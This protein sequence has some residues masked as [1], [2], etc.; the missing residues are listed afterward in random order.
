MEIRGRVL[1]NIGIRIVI[2]I[3][4]IAFHLQLLGFYL[5]AKETHL[6]SDTSSIVIDIGVVRSGR[7]AVK[8]LYWHI[9]H[10]CAT[11]T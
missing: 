7:S 8:L 11:C 9:L 2:E 5:F 3:R 6:G 4:I 1:P 10:C